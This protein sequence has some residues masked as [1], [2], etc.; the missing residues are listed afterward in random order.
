MIRS[1][2][3]LPTLTAPRAFR[4]VRTKS[5]FKPPYPDGVLHIVTK[6]GSLTLCGQVPFADLPDPR[7]VDDAK[8]VCRHCVSKATGMG[9]I[10]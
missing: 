2:T 4:Y 5:R 8:R 9:L 6:F 10:A 1:S 3:P 7:S